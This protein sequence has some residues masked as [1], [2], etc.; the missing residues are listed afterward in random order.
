MPEHRGDLNG[1]KKNAGQKTYYPDCWKPIAFVKKKSKLWRLKV[2]SNV[3]FSFTTWSWIAV[4]WGG[5]LFFLNVKKTKMV[6]NV[7]R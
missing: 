2:D 3:E 4:Q 6:G 1:S 7:H 5:S